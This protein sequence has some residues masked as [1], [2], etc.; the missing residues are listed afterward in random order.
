M[1]ALE[2]VKI[3]AVLQFTIEWSSYSIGSDDCHQAWGSLVCR[4]IN[5]N[6]NYIPTSTQRIGAWL[7]VM[8]P[9]ASYKFGETFIQDEP[10]VPA[11]AILWKLYEEY[12]NSWFALT[13]LKVRLINVE[14]RWWRQDGSHDCLMT[15]RQRVQSKLLRDRF[16]KTCHS[17][18]YL[19]LCKGRKMEGEMT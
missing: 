11:S 19:C 14:S 17:Q 4:W 16:I 15:K 18:N 6:L 13:K 5:V 10:K 9:I 12:L 8:H 1:N 3:I 2:L 7:N